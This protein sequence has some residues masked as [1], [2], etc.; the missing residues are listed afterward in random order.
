MPRRNLIVVSV[1]VAAVTGCAWFTEYGKREASAR[2][3]FKR[4][5]YDA[6]V[7]DTVASLKDNPQ[8]DPAIELIQEAFPQA[9]AEHRTRIEQ[10]KQSGNAFKWDGVVG[11]YR[12]LIRLNQ[13]Y[14]QLPAI[15]DSKTGQAVTLKVDDYTKDYSEARDNAAGSH[16]SAALGWMNQPGVKF[17]RRAAKEFTSAISFVSGYKNA[18]ELYDKARAGGMVRIAIM[19]IKDKTDSGVADEIME[20]VM[21]DIDRDSAAKEFVELVSRDNLEVLKQ[22]RDLLASG[23]L[24]PSAVAKV[25]QGVA[26]DKIVMG[27]IVKDRGKVSDVK[28]KGPYLAKGEVYDY[29][30]QQSY[31]V[32]AKYYV[33]NWDAN[34]SLETAIQILDAKTGRQDQR[35]T[36]SG[37]APRSHEWAEM[38]DGN[39]AAMKK[40]YEASKLYA[41]GEKDPPGEDELREEAARKVRIQVYAKLKDYFRAD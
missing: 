39:E 33:K 16:Y 20:G 22:E 37:D 10:A 9:V 8:Y 35:F 24:D 11:E 30:T 14:A 28:R 34:Y 15:K 5:D 1:L 32:T 4:G 27:K 21:T 6:A 31:K 26:V 3:A 13:A 19:P 41:A 25:P 7:Y 12:A 2:D 23:F 18:G 38:V 40:D 36:V 17:Q 29:K